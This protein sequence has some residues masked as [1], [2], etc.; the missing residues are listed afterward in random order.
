MDIRSLLFVAGSC[1]C[2]GATAQVSEGFAREFKAELT[3]KLRQVETRG[4]I[5]D[6]LRLDARRPAEAATV[7]E[8][9]VGR[10]PMLAE[11]R[12]T[13]GKEKL[14]SI[15]TTNPDGSRSMLQCFFY[16]DKGKEI[17]R[18][19]HYW[20]AATGSWDEPTERYDYV[21]NDDG[22][23]LS[24]QAVGYGGGVRMEYKYND[25]GL[26]IEQV[27]YQMDADGNWTPTSKGEY[28][29]DDNANIIEEYTY[30]WDG[31]QWVNAAHN[32]ASWDDKSRQTGYTGYSWDGT[33]WVGT[34]KGDYVW[35][36]GPR[37]P[38]YVEGTEAERMTYKGDYLWKDGRWQHY[39]IFTNEFNEDGRVVGQGEKVYNRQYGKWCGGDTWDGA[40]GMPVTWRGEM[41]YDEHGA[42][43]YSQ[44]WRC[45]P[46]SAGWY[47]AGVVP[48]EWTYDADGNREGLSKVI[49]YV[50]DDQYNK[51]GE[52]C[53]QQTYYGYNADNRKTW[54][55]E[56][57]LGASGEWESLFEEKYGYD[58]AGRSTYTMIWDWVDG[59]RRPTTYNTTVYDAD[60]NVIE[61]IGRSGDTG[62]VKP[63]GAP[64]TR[65]A[66]IE[67]DD[68]EG[69]VNTTRWVNV[70]ENG[71]R[72]E[73]RGY[74]WPD[75][76][77]TTN[78]GQLVDFDFDVRADEVYFPEGWTDPYKINWIEDL[79]ADGNNGWLA[80]K[81]AYYYSDLVAT[82][83][84]NAASDGDAG[85]SVSYKADRL[86]VEAPDVAVVRI[87][88]VDG[89]LV[90]TSAERSVFVGDMPAGIYVVAVGGYKTKIVK[91]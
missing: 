9:P 71:A 91:K 15:I 25:E 43:V 66:A 88:G 50:Y 76:E 83:I 12:T 87:Y 36:D 49:N 19:Y 32:L 72:V 10:A 17:K 13:E 74:R 79:Y 53:S 2:V 31:T 81:R 29:Y 37:D 78:S 67:P 60:G 80:S 77:W 1:F 3:P 65:G 40:L 45:M 82:A 4:M 64:A 38:D 28:A 90:R 39:Y 58:E 5:G 57:L 34:S 84:G 59:V 47:A 20:N 75:G 6:P 52:T 41:T 69:W 22:L 85:V 23:I 27:N 44:T 54:V 46:D 30:S 62:G 86:S 35:F 16:N 7:A 21:W 48:T 73:Q 33:Q 55:L 56:Q 51:T 42:Q 61:S 89:T 26:G 8:R 63:I 11:T 70:Y 24:E 18:T 14:D 68:E